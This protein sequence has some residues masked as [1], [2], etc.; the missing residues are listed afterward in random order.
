M[1]TNKRNN[2]LIIN[3][4]QIILEDEVLYNGHVIVESDGKIIGINK[5]IYY[6]YDDNN[7]F[8]ACYNCKKN[9]ATF[10]PAQ[11]D[12]CVNIYCKKCAMKMATG[13]RCKKCKNLFASMKRTSTEKKNVNRNNNKIINGVEYI[14][15]GF[16]DIHNHGLGGAKDVL[17]YWTN[18]EFS[19][20]K[21][22][23]VGVTSM[24]ATLTFPDPPRLKRS[25]KACQVLS[26]LYL[27]NNNY[28]ARVEGIVSVFY[29]TSSKF[30]FIAMH[31]LFFLT[32]FIS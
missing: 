28:G 9:Q 21:L 29:C 6:E 2:L 10:A 24:F 32:H 27:K 12:E 18:P 5:G 11:C 16:I 31:L 22:Y 13:G 3:A 25:L 30:L 7:K 15:P 4:K 8:N 23:K 20:R 14:I 26:E 1:Q 17:D 19:L